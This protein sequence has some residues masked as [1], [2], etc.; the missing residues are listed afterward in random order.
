MERGVLTGAQAP[1]RG[2]A[3]ATA[4]DPRAETAPATAPDLRVGALP[5]SAGTRTQGARVSGERSEPVQV[6]LI[7]GRP[8]RFVWRERLFTV[9]SVLERPA[10]EPEAPARPA[11]PHEDRAGRAGH[12]AGPVAWRCWRVTAAAVRNVPPST[13][14]LC[15]DPAADRWLLTRNGR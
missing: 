1:W 14:R 8:A 3:P 13:F 11:R 4:P 7:N 5:G 15:H 10:A 6:W 2:P 9:L 12:E